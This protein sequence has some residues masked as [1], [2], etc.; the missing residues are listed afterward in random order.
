MTGAQP[1]SGAASL[2][3]SPPALQRLRKPRTRLLEL[4]ERIQ[5]ALVGWSD[6]DGP[7][8]LR[9]CDAATDFLDRTA[10]LHDLD[11]VVL[12]ESR[13]ARNFVQQVVATVDPMTTLSVQ[14]DA[15]SEQGPTRETAV[16][17]AEPISVVILQL[18]RLAGA[19]RAL[20]GVSNPHENWATEATSAADHLHDEVDAVRVR[21]AH[22]AVAGPGPGADTSAAPDRPT[23]QSAEQL[24]E[25][26]SRQA[27]GERVTAEVTRGL[28]VLLY[29]V[30]AGLAWSVLWHSP[31]DVSALARDLAKLATAVP[32][33]LLTSYLQREAAHHRSAAARLRELAV[34][35]DNV[36]GYFSADERD[37][38]RT[39]IWDR[40][41]SGAAA[42]TTTP[43]VIGDDI[44][45]ILERIAELLK[46][47]GSIK[48]AD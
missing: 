45:T 13:L 26:L 21:R 7:E 27:K 4:V 3:D 8:I 34:Q 42:V 37:R 41:A 2:D 16:H 30:I 1:T 33:V 23:A 31:V 9:V 35:L 11:A 20:V 46:S 38:H 19:L 24:A 25:K 40:Y 44:A 48:R 12:K 6:P 15:L 10:A 18:I 17:L 36:D 29:L 47:L 5:D 14:V 32:L 22:R 43:P 39:A 28:V